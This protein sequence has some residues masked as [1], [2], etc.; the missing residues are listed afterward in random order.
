M[1]LAR[2][3][4][5]RLDVIIRSMFFPSDDEIAETLFRH[6]AV[7]TG[8]APTMAG[9]RAAQREVLASLGVPLSGVV[10]SSGSGRS[11]YDRFTTAAMVYLLRTAVDGDHPSMAALRNGTAATGGNPLLMRAGID[12]TLNTSYGRYSTSPSSCARGLVYA[13]TGS[14]AD[15]IALSGY[16]KGSDGR[17]KVFSV[18]VNSRPT[19]YSS[20][21]TR[22]HVDRIAATVTGCY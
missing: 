21:T 3:G 1:L 9:A 8:H 14:L 16:A 15:A 6:V 20:L 18:F 5:H 22:Q 17:W 4:G 2:Y 7:A 12:G 10:T 13:K 11:K 19:A